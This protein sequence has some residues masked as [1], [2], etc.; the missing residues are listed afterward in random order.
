MKVYKS[1]VVALLM[2]YA[3]TSCKKAA[4]NEELVTPP[5]GDYFPITTNSNW[6][7]VPANNTTGLSFESTLIGATRTVMG[8]TY[9]V[10][11]YNAGNPRVGNFWDSTLFRKE[12][13]K[14]YQALLPHQLPYPLTQTNTEVLEFVMMEDDAPLYTTWTSH[15]MSGTFTFSNGSTGIETTITTYLSDY[16]PTFQLDD[17]HIFND[18]VKV[19]V[20]TNSK[21]SNSPVFSESKYYENWYAR[22]VGLIKTVEPLFPWALKL[23]SYKVY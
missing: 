1:F 5:S 12:G 22:G 15:I 9:R 3:L 6:R 19:S 4:T 16:Y 8:K 11:N 14:Y 23:S 21:W 10:L 18:V 7:Y 20:R 17:T 2:I 13:G